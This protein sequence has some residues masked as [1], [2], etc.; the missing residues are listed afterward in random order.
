MRLSRNVMRTTLVMLCIRAF[1]YSAVAPSGLAAVTVSTCS[2]P[3]L[4]KNFIEF[5]VI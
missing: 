1:K 3:E 5:F 4:L 2:N